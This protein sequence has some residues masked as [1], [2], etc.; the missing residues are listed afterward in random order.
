MPWS[1]ICRERNLRALRLTARFLSTGAASFYLLMVI[2]SA[3][4]QSGPIT[5]EGFFV[6]LFGVFLLAGSVTSYR[7]ERLGGRLLTIAGLAFAVFVYL[8]AGNSK[9]SA[10]LLLSLPFVLAGVL[11]LIIDRCRHTTR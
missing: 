10:A 8:S 11:F 2:G 3:L 6:G 9:L 7:R 1:F 4:G 5:L